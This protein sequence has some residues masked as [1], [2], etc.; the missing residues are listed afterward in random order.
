MENNQLINFEDKK[1]IA[2]LKQTVAKDATDEEFSMFARFCQAT[3]LNPFKKEV[4]FIKTKSGVQMMTGINGFWAIAN[5]HPM[6]DGFEQDVEMDAQ[7]N[8]I[9]AWTKVYRKDRKFPSMGV[10]LLKEYRKGSPIWQQMPSAMILKCSESIALRKAFS[11]ELNGLYTAE[12]M[13]PEYSAEVTQT[14]PQVEIKQEKPVEVETPTYYQ[15]ENITR[16][17]QLYIEKR[18]AIFD[19]T[20]LLWRAP[21]NLGPKLE[22]YKVEKREPLTLEV[23][24]EAA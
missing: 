5:N 18:G 17:Q 11:Q 15:I 21:K 14:G 6:F 24:T 23:E 10:A 8:L 16:D 13:P 2:T 9:K 1:T 22:K 3:R 4:W 12:E 20:L 7:G 19:D